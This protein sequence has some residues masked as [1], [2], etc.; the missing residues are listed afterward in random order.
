MIEGLRQFPEGGDAA[1]S[2]K[3]KIVAEAA[4]AHHEEQLKALKAGLVKLEP[5]QFE[6]FIKALLDAMDSART[7]ELRI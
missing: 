2:S 1:P 5:A 4:R 3:R 6:H 7:F